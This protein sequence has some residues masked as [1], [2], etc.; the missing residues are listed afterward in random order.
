[1]LLSPRVLMLFCD[2]AEAL[3]WKQGVVAN[4]QESK[5]A[6]QGLCVDSSNE[7]LARALAIVWHNA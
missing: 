3:G 6:A 7:L 5:K 1:M 4:I 2:E